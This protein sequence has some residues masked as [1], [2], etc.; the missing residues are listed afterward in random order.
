MRKI[1]I[2]LA[3]A[4][5]FAAAPLALAPLTAQDAPKLPGS[6]D[7]SLVTAGTYAT[8][9]SHTLIGWRVNHFGFNDY[10]GVFGDATGTLVMDPANPSA[11][12]VDITIPIAN[13]ST[14]SAGLTKHMLGKDFFEAETHA[15]AR[16]VSTKVTVEGTNAVI[17]GNLTIKGVTKPVTLDARFTG[18]GTNP[19][20]KKE[21]VGFEADTTIKRSD[22]G[23]AYGIPMVSDE[24]A[25]GISVAFEKAPAA[26]GTPTR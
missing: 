13:L 22:F 16:F 21:T 8:D 12:T 24:V 19:Y 5:S 6:M 18:V 11:A 15:S 23:I 2:V 4:A 14:A 17:E 7:A 26:A 25:L 10:F 20:S 3:S 9:P 1:L